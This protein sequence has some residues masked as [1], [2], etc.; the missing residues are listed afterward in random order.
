MP[1]FALQANM[2]LFPFRTIQTTSTIT[3]TQWL[4]RF[5]N[6]TLCHNTSGEPAQ[7]LVW[8]VGNIHYHSLDTAATYEN[9]NFDV[10]LSADIGNSLDNLLKTGPWRTYTKPNRHCILRTKAYAGR[11]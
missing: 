2:Q 11:G 10:V 1:A 9:W 6:Y 7:A 3:I 4:E 8:V 5:L